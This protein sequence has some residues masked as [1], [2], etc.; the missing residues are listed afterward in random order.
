MFEDASTGVR[1]REWQF[2]DGA[3]SRAAT[4]SHSWSTPG[5]Y[6]V[7]LTVSDGTVESR[8]SRVFLVVAS[9]PVGACV[10]DEGTLCS[11]DSRFATTVDWWTLEGETGAGTVVRSGTN[12]SGMF[13][14]YSRDNWEVLVKVLNGCQVNGAVW[15]FAGSTTDV[16]YRIAVE[17]TVTGAVREYRN[18]AGQAAAA[19]TDTGAFPG[20]CVTG[21][22]ASSLA[23]SVAQWGP[24]EEA[25]S[26]ADVPRAELDRQD[27]QDGQDGCTDSATSLCLRDGR[28]TVTVDWSTSAGEFGPGRVVSAKSVDSGL[29]YFFEP[30]NWEMLV[31]VLD[32]CAFNERH[33]V[34]AASATDLG[35]NLVVRDTETGA[36]RSYTK[37]PGKAAP[38]LVDV[39]AFPDSC[40]P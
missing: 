24:M 8:A 38:A 21:R 4:V 2:G 37:E 25:P 39:G 30:G 20:G 14:F 19:V 31:K 35:L 34:F 7:T 29:F 23:T 16:G 36:V 17:D 40:R 33:W 1:S 32:G 26:V 9:E 10:A 15:V 12:D 22:V 18:E 3:R 6:E 13:W 5:F 27:E 28:Y 11:Q